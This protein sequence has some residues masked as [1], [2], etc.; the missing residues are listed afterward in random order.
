[1]YFIDMSYAKNVAQRINKDII[2]KKYTSG[3]GLSTRQSAV[4]SQL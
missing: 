4:Y 3:V 2:K 1:M